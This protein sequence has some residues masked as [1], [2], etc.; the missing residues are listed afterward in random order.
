MR[1]RYSNKTTNLGRKY[2]RKIDKQVRRWYGVHHAGVS[3]DDLM[4]VRSGNR[5]LGGYQLY[6]PTIM[7]SNFAI[8][9]SGGNRVGR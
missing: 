2:K 8:M 6:N 7:D 1:N 5:N 4:R 3:D 9:G